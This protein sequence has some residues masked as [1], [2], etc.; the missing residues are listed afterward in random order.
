MFKVQSSDPMAP[1]TLNVEPEV[2]LL[3]AHPENDS[4][5]FRCRWPLES[6]P[7]PAPVT[8]ACFAVPLGHAL[9][10]FAVGE[11][12]LAS[13]D[14]FLLLRRRKSMDDRNGIA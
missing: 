5:L 13:V 14:D 2:I 1:L 6:S 9:P 7:S 8:T 11:D 3:I 12:R 4:N 10:L